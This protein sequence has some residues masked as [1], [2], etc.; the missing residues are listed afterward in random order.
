MGSP[1]PSL[2]F[3]QGRLRLES[4]KYT[5]LQLRALSNDFVQA[6][7]SGKGKEEIE[8]EEYV[9]A[10]EPESLAEDSRMVAVMQRLPWDFEGSLTSQ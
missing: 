6:E 9:F 5:A 10:V 8:F 2:D 3:G 7:V 4:A 1:G